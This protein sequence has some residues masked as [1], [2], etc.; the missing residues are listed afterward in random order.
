MRKMVIC[1]GVTRELD[2]GTRPSSKKGVAIFDD[3]IIVPTSDI[4]ILALEAKTGITCR[5]KSALAG[6][7]GIL[8]AM[9]QT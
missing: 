2:E 4:H 5:S 7:C 3:K 6:L 1:C 8:A 9:I